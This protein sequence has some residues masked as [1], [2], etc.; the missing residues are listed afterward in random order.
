MP[1]PIQVERLYQGLKLHF[2]STL[3]IRHQYVL[4]R[5]FIDCLEDSVKKYE[6]YIIQLIDDLSTYPN[7]LSWSGMDPEDIELDLAL[8]DTL[9]SELQLSGKCENFHEISDNLKEVCLLLFSCLNDASGAGKYLHKIYDIRGI[10]KTVEDQPDILG[11]V[12][13]LLAT[14]FQNQNDIAKERLKKLERLIKQ[15]DSIQKEESGSAFV[16]V[17]EIYQKSGSAKDEY[18]RLRKISV[19]LY[20]ESNLKDELIWNMNVLGAEKPSVSHQQDFLHAARKLYKL[21]NSTKANTYYRGGVRFELSNA[22]HEGNSANLAAA[23]LW[24]TQLLR[25]SGQRERY[26]VNSHAAITGDVYSDGSVQQVDSMTIPLKIRAAFFSWAKIIVAPAEQS[27]QFEE[28]LQKLQEKYPRRKLYVIGVQ[29]L[30]EAFFDRRV[31]AHE[32]Q[33]RMKYYF[34]RMRKEK[35]RI[36]I[37]LIIILL[38]VIARLGYGPVDRNAVVLEFIDNHIAL[39]NKTGGVIKRIDSNELTRDN[40]TFSKPMAVLHDVTGDGKNE[41]IYSNRSERGEDGTPKI[42]VWS[43]SGDSLIW[44]KEYALNYDFP[45]QNTPLVSGLRPTEIRVAQTSKGNR[46]VLNSGSSQYFQGVIFVFSAKTGDLLS[47]YVHTG[48]IRDIMVMDLNLDGEDEIIL[49]GVNNAYWEAFVAVLD[50]NNAHGYSPATPDYQPAGIERAE[51]MIYA[52]IPKTIIGKYVEFL[53]KYNQ[54]MTLFYD[55]ASEIVTILVVEGWK[56]FNDLEG[57]VETLIYFD[58]YMKPVGFGTSDTYDVVAKEL[59][60]KGEIQ[61]IPDFDYFEAFQDSLLYWNGNEFV[62]TQEYFQKL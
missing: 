3:S 60:E 21:G 10:D 26:I 18:G 51:E 47:E 9:N 49:T 46:I 14:Q 48:Q 6:T 38:F 15:I 1:D 56:Y 28:E 27:Q 17:A 41:L 61:E 58:R 24:Y 4:F 43:V 22:V 40:H 11:Q 2:E 50:V 29:E 31:A 30:K 19:E 54:G 37:P 8:L 39:K 16:P 52:R 42:R 23:M 35:T 32:V 7:P 13:K 25:A 36:L 34:S 62:T 44:E 20:G 59:Y 45:R 55:E 57:L 33:G 5:R 53:D 12:H